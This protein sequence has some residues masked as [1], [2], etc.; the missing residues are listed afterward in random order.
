[1]TRITFNRQHGGASSPSFDGFGGAFH[2]PG[3]DAFFD[4]LRLLV[5]AGIPDSPCEVVDELGMPCF[6]FQSIHAGA[7]RYRPTEAQR[8]ARAADRKATVPG[9]P[10]NDV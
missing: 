7:R 3:T 10:Q 9:K 1:M 4:V 6:T 5:D 2:A 8:A